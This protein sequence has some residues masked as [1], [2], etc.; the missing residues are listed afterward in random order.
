M[1]SL[2]CFFFFFP[3][4][5]LTPCVPTLEKYHKYFFEG[6]VTILTYLTEFLQSRDD[7]FVHIGLWILAQFSTGGV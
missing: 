3:P 4:F 7:N 2:L 6:E 1:Q 5:F